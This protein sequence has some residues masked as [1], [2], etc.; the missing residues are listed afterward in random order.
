MTTNLRGRPAKRRHQVLAYVK[1]TVATEGRAPSYGM[2]CTALGMNSRQDVY[3]IVTRL[4][5][6]GHLHRAGQGRVRRI[7]LT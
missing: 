4:E 2:I 1:A 5:K 6:D 7:N 3:Q